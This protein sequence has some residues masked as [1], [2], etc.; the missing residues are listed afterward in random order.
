MLS[1]CFLSEV[2]DLTAQAAMFF[3]ML[4]QVMR[5]KLPLVAPLKL[6]KSRQHAV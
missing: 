5:S 1:D 4:R 3:M 2:I 6:T